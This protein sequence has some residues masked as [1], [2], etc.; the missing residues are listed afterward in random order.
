[1]SSGTFNTCLACSS[2]ADNIYHQLDAVGM[3]WRGYNQSM[4]KNC[5]ANASSVPYYRDGHNPAFWFTDLGPAAKGGDGSCAVDD[6]PADP[7]M[8]NDISADALP[9]FAWVAPD[10]CRDMHWMNGPCETVT[11]QTKAQRIAIGDAYIKQVV[12]A[13]AATPS[14]Q[15][16]KTLVVVTWDES[17]EQ[18]T[19]AK[20]NW[21]IDCSNPA[22]YTGNKA[23]CQVVTI[24]VS[25]RLSGGTTSTFY[26]HYSL[27][28]AFESNFG[29]PLLAGATDSWVTPAPIY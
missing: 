23:T 8:W 15:A 5:A 7:N 9:S 12:N 11:G 4:P 10:D 18:S 14:Y 25:A 13:I 2:G 16:G 1:V 3:S 28:A 21:G 24:L 6:V 26:S 19:Q 27:T 20:G 29:L 17:N 22:V